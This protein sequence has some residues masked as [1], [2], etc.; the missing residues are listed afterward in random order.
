MTYELK[1]FDDFDLATYN[2][3]SF[4]R[5]KNT[6]YFLSSKKIGKARKRLHVYIYE[7]ETG[8]TVKRGY[9]VHHKDG[10]KLNNDISNLEMIDKKAHEQYHVDH[11]TE[12]RKKQMAETI[13]KYGVPAAREWHKT[14]AGHEWHVEHGKIV[15]A[16][17]PLRKYVCDYCGNV[18]YTKNIYPADSNTFCSNKCKAAARRKSGVDNVE[19]ICPICG[20]R[21]ATNKYSPAKY[22]P[23]HRR[24]KR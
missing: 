19:K 13:V 5:D 18:Y 14:D 10:D 9:H 15:A 8:Q 3:Y 23:L 7:T 2:G 16:N 12:E 17:M 21:Y 22:C 6:G 4:R 11:L 1:Y 20:A 24:G